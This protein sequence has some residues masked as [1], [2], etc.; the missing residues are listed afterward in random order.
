MFTNLDGRTVVPEC[1]GAVRKP[2]T[3]VAPSEP[4]SRSQQA[5]QDRQVP[6]PVT[7]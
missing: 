4:T 7:V 1:Y 5:L 2:R 6:L 3:E